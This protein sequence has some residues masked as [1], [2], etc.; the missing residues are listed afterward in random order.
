MESNQQ[1]AMR[2]AVSRTVVVRY[3]GTWY[4]ITP[5]AYEPE[6][7]T[8]QIAWSQIREGKSPASAYRD[9]FKSEQ[10]EMK[11]FYPSFRKDES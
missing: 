9:W 2:S 6:R 11:L 1:E 10:N 4:R 8:F 7:Q 3:R 5:K